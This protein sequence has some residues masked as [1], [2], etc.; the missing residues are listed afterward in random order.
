[1]LRTRQNGVPAYRRIQATILKQIE[2]GRLSPGD[3]V[4]SERELAKIHDVSLMTA[5][6]ALAALERE[7]IVERKRGSGT[8]VAPPKIHF[9]KLMSFSEQLS[10]RSLPS[11]SKILSRT[12]VNDGQQ[13]AA[14]LALPAGSPLLKL[15][16][17]RMG[18][19]DPFALETCYLSEAEFSGVGTAPLHRGSLFSTLEHQYGVELQYS[20]EEIDAT[21]ADPKT[22]KLLGIPRGFPLLRFRQ[23]IYSAKGKPTLY[24]LGVYRSDR[25]NL[26]IRRFR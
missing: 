14:A 21:A 26:V 20:D 7:G 25:H 18:S 8:F 22:S 2:S 19:T 12:V 11:T 6:H 13:I 17:L 3:A 9:N 15:E 4:S 24:V 16:R 5:R 23:V 1:M 10:G